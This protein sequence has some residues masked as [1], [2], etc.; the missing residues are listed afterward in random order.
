MFDLVESSSVTQM[1][2]IHIDCCCHIFKV[3]PVLTL[4]CLDNSVSVRLTDS[5]LG[6]VG[7]M[8]GAFS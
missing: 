5:T 1:V 4:G 6:E 8:V 2:L 7:R 3:K